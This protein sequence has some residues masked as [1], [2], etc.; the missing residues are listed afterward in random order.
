M[1]AFCVC[2]VCVCVHSVCVTLYH[3]ELKLPG[4]TTKLKDT[5]ADFRLCILRGG[6][7]FWRKPLEWRD[8][9]CL[10]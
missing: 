7:R 1:C 5:C 4:G 9:N 10:C 2:L 6:L 3:G 8:F